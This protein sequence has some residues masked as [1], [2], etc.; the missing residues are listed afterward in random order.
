[1]AILDTIKE[2]GGEVKDVFINGLDTYAQVYAE[3]AGERAGIKPTDPAVQHDRQDD[4]APLYNTSTQKPENTGGMQ[5]D[6]RTIGLSVAAAALL[7]AA[8]AYL[9]KR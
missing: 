1:M 3:S 5:W 2:L 4:D 8:V 6:A 7:V 9:A